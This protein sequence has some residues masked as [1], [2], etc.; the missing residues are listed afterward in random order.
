MCLLIPIQTKNATN[1]GP[2]GASQIA[3]AGAP[4]RV[5][6]PWM[7]LIPA[8]RKNRTTTPDMFGADARDTRES[9][10]SLTETNRSPLPSARKNGYWNIASRD[11]RL[12][13]PLW[14]GKSHILV[15]RNVGCSCKPRN[16]RRF[17]LSHD[18]RG[19]DTRG[20][21]GKQDSNRS[22]SFSNQSLQRAVLER[23]DIS[24]GCRNSVRSSLFGG[25]PPVVAKF[26]RSS[27]PLHLN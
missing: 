15:A 9:N 16:Y 21:L 11:S 23:E 6:P 13:S 7:A 12:R 22:V 18:T 10:W 14:R 3:S 27:T 25:S 2:D 5:W 24:R 19:K 8:A 4:S 20:W 26:M 1:S 17:S